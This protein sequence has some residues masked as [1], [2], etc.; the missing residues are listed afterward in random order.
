MLEKVA[1]IL[2][3]AFKLYLTFYSV[4]ELVFKNKKILKDPLNTILNI[5]KRSIKSMLFMSTGIL[6]YRASV[7]IFS[8]YFS[9]TNILFG[10]IQ[11]YL[12]SL[13]CLWENSSRSITYAL[14]MYP[15][16][17]DGLFDMLN[18]MNV[19]PV[20]PGFIALLFSLTMSTGLYLKLDGKMI[21]SYDYIL[22]K[23]LG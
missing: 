2:P 14:F 8:K 5:I 18:K 19:L 4:N 23:V 9:N 6:A 17:L 3:Y 16:S 7:C 11:C 22:N 10:I 21:E 15:K 13:G 1:I 20:I 12:S